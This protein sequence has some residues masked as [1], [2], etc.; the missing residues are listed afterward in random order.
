MVD[1]DRAVM[2]SRT[3]FLFIPPGE[4]KQQDRTALYRLKCGWPVAKINNSLILKLPS[5][6]GKV[7]PWVLQTHYVMLHGNCQTQMAHIPAQVGVGGMS[8]RVK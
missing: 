7:Q 2:R 5:Y 4:Y 8:A 1:P 6:S 3:S